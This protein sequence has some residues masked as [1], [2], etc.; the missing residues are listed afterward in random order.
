[1]RYS[2]ASVS[3]SCFFTSAP[4]GTAPGPAGPPR[5]PPPGRPPGP[6]GR[7]CGWESGVETWKPGPAEASMLYLFTCRREGWHVSNEPGARSQRGE[8]MRSG[9]ARTHEPTAHP[10]A[11][12][13]R[14]ISTGPRGRG[15]GTF[16]QRG[17][18]PFVRNQ[19][20]DAAHCRL[21]GQRISQLSRHAVN[22]LPGRHVAPETL[23]PA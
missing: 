18:P 10:A 17:D 12:A 15:I 21:R 22:G 19:S 6:P 14:R 9:H 16:G 2:S 5:P 3:L 4:P 8:A 11:C 13:P 23:Y 7:G 20:P 1:L